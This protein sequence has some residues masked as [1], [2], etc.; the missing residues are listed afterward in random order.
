MQELFMCNH[1]FGQF[2]MTLFTKLASQTSTSVIGNMCTGMRDVW[3]EK[4]GQ[5]IV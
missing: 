2:K 4:I 1:R 5:E 3:R